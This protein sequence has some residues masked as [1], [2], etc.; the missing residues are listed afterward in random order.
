[1]RIE[2]FTEFYIMSQAYACIELFR[3]LEVRTFSK[4][5]LPKPDQPDRFRRPCI[6]IHLIS[7]N[8]Q[9]YRIFE[10]SLI[11]Q[12]QVL[13]TL[14]YIMIHQLCYKLICA[15]IDLT[16]TGFKISIPRFSILRN[17]PHWFHSVPRNSMSPC[18]DGI[19]SVF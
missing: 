15:Y 8:N 17:I 12:C 14:A 9:N 16:I 10:E 4:L 1:M 19:V 11:F 13:P 6:T 2:F 18:I 7:F 3:T 5:V